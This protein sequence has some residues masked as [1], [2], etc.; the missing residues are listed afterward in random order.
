MWKRGHSSTVA[1]TWA[2][3]HVH[4]SNASCNSKKLYVVEMDVWLPGHDACKALVAACSNIL[5][6]SASWLMGFFG[7]DLRDTHHIRQAAA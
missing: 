5:S 6:V 4:L 3:S 7:S 2:N 1:H